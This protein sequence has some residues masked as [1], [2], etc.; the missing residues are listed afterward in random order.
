MIQSCHLVVLCLLLSWTCHGN[1]AFHPVK[2]TGCTLSGGSNRPWTIR[3]CTHAPYSLSLHTLTN[4]QLLRGGDDNDEEQDTDDDQQNTEGD[5]EDDTTDEQDEQTSTEMD[6][7]PEAIIGE[8]DND[9]GTLEGDEYDEE[10]EEIEQEEAE[11]QPT[12]NSQPSLSNN[13]ESKR[14]FDEPFSLSPIQELSVTVGSM[15]LFSKLNLNDSKIIRFARCVVHLI[16]YIP[17]SSILSFF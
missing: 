12:L 3:C 15:F 11:D 14:A 9:N 10:D 2:R 6:E 4:L 13:V 1:I 7:E 5:E 8:E 16:L 17:F